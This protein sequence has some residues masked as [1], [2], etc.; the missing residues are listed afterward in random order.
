[1]RSDRDY[2]GNGTKVGFAIP[3]WLLGRKFSREINGEKFSN[4]LIEKKKRNEWMVPENPMPVKGSPTDHEGRKI[5]QI[6]ELRFF[7]S[8]NCH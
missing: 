3:K 8:Q 1:M 2:F 7:S 5:P 4:A 6:L